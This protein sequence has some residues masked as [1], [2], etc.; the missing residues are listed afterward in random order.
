MAYALQPLRNPNSF[1][2]VHGLHL[3]LFQAIL[4]STHPPSRV[5]SLD[6]DCPD[7]FVPVNY[8]SVHRVRTPGIRIISRQP[9]A[10]RS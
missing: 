2:R 8:A 5:V 4:A 10:A 6:G 7:F 1:T 3:S 9:R